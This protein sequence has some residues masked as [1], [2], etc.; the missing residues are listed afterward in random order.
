MTTKKKESEKGFEQSL[1]RLESIVAEMERG[2]LPLDDM[3]ARFEEGQGL[4]KACQN[5]LNEVKKKVELLIKKD[6]EFAGVDFACPENDE[7][8]EHDL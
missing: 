2:N 7:A 5:K 8:Q 6:G 4:L 3:I 1:G